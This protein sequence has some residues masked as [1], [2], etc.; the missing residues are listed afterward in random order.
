VQPVAASLELITRVRAT[1][2][3]PLE[4]GQTPWGRRRVIGVTGGEFDGPM[5]R[6]KVLP[7]G[8]DWQIVHEDGAATID[9]RYTLETHDGALIYVSTRGCRTGPREVLAR[10]AAGEMVDPAEYYFRVSIQ[11]ETSAPEYEWLNWVVA[12][13]SALRLADQVIYDAYVVR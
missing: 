1:L 3:E 10:I 2:A 8:A 7:G 11:Y 6:G 4:L 9:T 12:V 13:A 5:L